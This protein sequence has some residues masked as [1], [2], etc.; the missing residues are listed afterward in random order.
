MGKIFFMRLNKILLFLLIAVTIL[1]ACSK[2][3]LDQRPLGNLDDQGIKTKAG[4]EGLLVGAYSLLD[5]V[6]S[7]NSNS[8]WESAGSNWLYGSVCGSE[9]HKGTQ[10]NDQPDMQSIERFKTTANNPFMGS[11]WGTLYDGAQRCND[12]I[13]IMRQVNSLTSSDT[14]QYR[15]EAL[16]L[17]AHYHIEAKLMWNR[18]PFIDEYIIYPN[19]DYKVSN[20]EEIWPRIEE[21]LGYAVAHL[22]EF[23]DEKGK[24]NRYTALALLAKA[25]L[26]QHKY[27]SAKTVLD[28]IIS[29]G[30]YSLGKFEDNFN[31]AIKNGPESVFAAQSTV[32][33]NAGGNNGNLG[34]I[35]NYPNG[36]GPVGCC[37]FFQP[38]QYL[39]NHFKTDPSTG[40]PDL[41]NYNLVDVKND[42][43]LLS[44]D[45]FVP[46][47]GSLDPRLDHTVGRRGIPYLDWGINP[48]DD[49]IREQSSG[50]PYTPIKNMY[51]KSQAGT[52]SDITFWTTGPNAININL[53]RYAEILLWAAEAEVLS[54]NGS[55]SKAQG[56]VNQ[57]RSRA[58]DPSG[59][60][61]K[62]KDDQH[63]ELGFSDT[64]AANYHV[65]PYP[66][67]WTDPVFALKAIR[68]ESMLE[69]G[70]EGH[71]FFDLVRWG[72]AET[73]INTYLVKEKNITGYLAEAQFDSTQDNYFPIP[74]SE[75]DKTDHHLIQNPNY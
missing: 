4:V 12:V 67:T 21:D 17:R 13:R 25:F 15:A 65:N 72:I 46:Y 42:V 63:P 18:V 10:S 8:P 52:Y 14:V 34:D 33:D 75:I 6:G 22:P 36:S 27:D 30:K 53:I 51:L 29:S 11:K 38:S 7:P 19:D 37:G 9:A 24:V 74:Q 54:L 47:T 5:G 49:W 39:V 71:R 31:A 69:L 64:A 20:A 48:G 57:L 50:G 70:M 55:L 59:W 41:D 44:G 16:C 35:L 73:E 40:L 60:V 2:N 43:G 32:N 23:Q 61:Y 1:I 68:Y 56:Y 58:A 26:F 62:Y 66:G 45:P 28:I 3:L